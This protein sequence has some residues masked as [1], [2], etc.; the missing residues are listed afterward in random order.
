MEIYAKKIESELLYFT[1]L[2]GGRSLEGW[3]VT[4]VSK[5]LAEIAD[6][7]YGHDNLNVATVVGFY[8]NIEPRMLPGDEV[9]IDLV[10]NRVRNIRFE[11]DGVLEVFQNLFIYY[12]S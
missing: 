11:R 2:S 6:G 8:R 5:M 1:E 10:E 9:W 12:E 7:D 3:G 4:G